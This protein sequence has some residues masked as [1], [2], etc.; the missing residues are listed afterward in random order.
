MAERV[1]RLP[2]FANLEVK[3]RRTDVAGGADPADDLP[4]ADDVPAIDQQRLV[5]GVSG[6][7]ALRVPD[8]KEIAETTELAPGV[9]HDTVLGGVYRLPLVSDDIDAVVISP[10]SFG[11]IAVDDAALDRP[12]ERRARARWDVGR[13][14]SPPGGGRAA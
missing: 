7:P 8:E 3:L 12:G 4:A 11:A 6:D 1:H 14:H 10:T 13:C 2:S 5:V 9:R